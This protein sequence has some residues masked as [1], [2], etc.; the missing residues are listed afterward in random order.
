M[1]CT[2]NV[3]PQT[4]K[5]STHSQEIGFAFTFLVSG[6]SIGTGTSSARR[7]PQ[8]ATMNITGSLLG[9]TSATCRCS[10]HTI[11][12]GT[13]LGSS[14]GHCVQQ[15][16]WSSYE[17]KHLL[18]EPQFQLLGERHESI[19]PCSH[20]KRSHVLSFSCIQRQ[21]VKGADYTILRLEGVRVASESFHYF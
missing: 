20:N 2:V 15:V 16:L 1:R 11:V 14:Q 7:Q 8:K 5:M 10:T 12:Y 17:I 9:K 19:Y 21:I 3:E 4:L 18:L 13:M 6:T